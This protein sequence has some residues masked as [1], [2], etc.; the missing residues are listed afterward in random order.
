MLDSPPETERWLTLSQA[1]KELG[2]HVTTL[3]R[4]AD[5]GDIPVMLT[6]GGHRRFAASDLAR[7]AQERR[8]QGSSDLESAFADK[9]LT[10]T[11]QEIVVRRDKAWLSGLDDSARDRYRLLGRQLLG[12]TLQYLSDENGGDILTE[13]SNIGR[14]YGEI[15]LQSR[16]PLPE[17]LEA[18]MFFRDMLMETALQ[19]PENTRIR[20]EA[21]VRLLRR[22]NR[23]LNTV[24][25]AIAE[26]YD[27]AS[28]DSLSR[29]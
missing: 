11:R 16:L 7:F 23:L 20:P 1:A 21:N 28:T 27:A 14:Q 26:V 9:A 2:V 12:L 4:W 24:Q 8:H 3:R 22:V 10:Q 17:A 13:A 18:S 5:N 6:P 19:L 29:P 25:L 15:G